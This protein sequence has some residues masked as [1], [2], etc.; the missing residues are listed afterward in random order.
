MILRSQQGQGALVYK[1]ALLE[2]GDLKPMSVP[3]PTPENFVSPGS[4]LDTEVCFR[5]LSE[6]R[7]SLRATVLIVNS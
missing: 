6:V 2:A 4:G 5:F 1:H 3:M 7:P